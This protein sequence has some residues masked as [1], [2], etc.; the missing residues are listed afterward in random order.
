VRR[1]LPDDAAELL[2]LDVSVTILVEE[3]E[4][5]AHTLALQSAE[6]LCELWVGHGVPVLLPAEV[7]LCPGTVPVERNVVVLA[8]T[9]IL[10]LERVEV[11]Q[12]GLFVCEQL[13]GN[14][15]FGVG[16]CKEVV[17]DRPVVDVNALLLV[18]IGN[19]EEDGVLL[20]LNLVLCRCQCA[21]GRSCWHAERVERDKSRH[22]L[23]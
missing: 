7:E 3:E 22:S 14:I 23:T 19:G 20:A 5:L 9:S 4:G 11:D 6:H 12:A 1:G 21:V 16:L 2:R 8:V 15:V 13:E 10:F 18:T 17:E